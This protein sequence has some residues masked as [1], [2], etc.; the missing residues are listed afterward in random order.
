M[1]FPESLRGSEDCELCQRTPKAALVIKSKTKTKHWEQNTQE[2][3]LHVT[4]LNNDP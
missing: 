4:G 2:L 3:K 1:P